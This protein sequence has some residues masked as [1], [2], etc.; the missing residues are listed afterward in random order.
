MC[1]PHL[2]RFLT[3]R[4][5]ARRGL[6]HGGPGP[7][8]SAQIDADARGPRHLAS[9]LLPTREPSLTT[10]ERALREV[11]LEAGAGESARA[12]R[13]VLA[14]VLGA[15]A[16]RRRIDV[17]LDRVVLAVDVGAADDEGMEG[18]VPAELVDL[19]N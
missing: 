6:G 4:S 18:R 16:G 8:T 17:A 19:S 5:R 1:R 2:D 12:D 15:A 13:R 7:R 14:Y 3:T 9:A 11:R 10:E